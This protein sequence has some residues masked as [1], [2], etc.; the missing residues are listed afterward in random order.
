MVNVAQMGDLDSSVGVAGLIGS[1]TGLTFTQGKHPPCRFVSRRKIGVQRRKLRGND[2]SSIT[3]LVQ[4]PLSWSQLTRTR[5]SRLRD[6]LGKEN[7]EHAI[8]PR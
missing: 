2:V 5:R 7:R 1:C 8:S 6:G 4:N 3:A